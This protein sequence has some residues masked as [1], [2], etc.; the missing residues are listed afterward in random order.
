[1]NIGVDAR[2]L[3]RKM[4]GIGRSLNTFLNELPNFDKKNKYFLFS[5]ERL[6]FNNSFFQNVTT[7]RSI[8]PQKLFAPIWMNFVLPKYLKKN[9]I[10]LFFSANQVVPIRKVKKTKYI[11]VLNDV[12]Y[13]VDKSFH[14]FIYRKYLQFFAYFSVKNS[15]LII[16]I[17]EYSKRD[18]LKYYKV[19]EEKIKVVY[20]AAEKKFRPL[21]LS[22]N[23]RTEIRKSLGLSEYIILYLGMIENRKNISGI[24]SIADKL[25]GHRTD[26]KFLLIGKIGYGG[27]KLL[28]EINRRTNVVYMQHID[29]NL[30]NKIFNISFVFLF[31]SFYE[32]FGYP[33]LEAMQSGLPVLSSNTTSLVEIVNNGGLMHS[34]EDYDSFKADIL[35]LLEDKNY[36]NEIKQKGFEQA[37]KFNI[38]STTKDLVEIFNSFNSKFE[39]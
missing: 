28:K 27:K 10:D 17:S 32:G 31:P 26:L 29:D 37:K 3:E 14:P 23:Q 39:N 25:G 5:Y 1:M 7:G 12:I 22:E 24:L 16:T 21:N 33:P 6:N 35:R 19:K 9:K 15:D 20:L 13:K 4:T 8:I 2:I 11:L 30:L 36:Y 38:L 18:I 34:P